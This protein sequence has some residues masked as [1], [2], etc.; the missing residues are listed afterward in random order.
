MA[1][2][3]VS[4]I[5]S[6]KERGKYQGILGSAIAVG[7]GIGP[8]IGAIFSQSASWRWYIILSFCSDVR[9]FRFSVPFAVVIMIQIY[10]FLPLTKVSGNMVSKLKKIDY[11]GSLISLAA[12]VFVLVMELVFTAK[13]RFPLAVVGLLTPGIVPSSLFF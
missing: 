11:F 10:F 7:G 3:I 6:L 4:D 13:Y 5:V 9:V 12:T 8:L 2:I 1:M